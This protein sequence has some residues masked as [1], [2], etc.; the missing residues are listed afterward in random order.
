MAIPSSVDSTKNRE[1]SEICTFLQVLGNKLKIPQITI[2]SA[3]V[4]FH[5]FYS[6]YTFEEHNANIVSYACLFLAA[7][8]EES[9]VRL[10][11]L[12]VL[13]H[14]LKY[15]KQ[16][17]NLESAEFKYWRDEILQKERLLL[18]VLGFDFQIEHPYTSMLQKV[19]QL[20]EEDQKK[21]AQLAWDFITE[22][23]KTSLCIQFEAKEIASACLYLALQYSKSP[24]CSGTKSEILGCPMDTIKQISII[25][26]DSLDQST[27]ADTNKLTAT[28]SGV[29]AP[30]GEI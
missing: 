11:D 7:K 30:T 8:V 14:Q 6:K 1:R 28:D 15:S 3:I 17:Q 16:I 27:A 24:L 13:M 5:R 2:A 25:I 4:L 21:I 23:L 18:Q 10:R 12:I 22:S 26:L 9:I 29:G 19:K 20:Q